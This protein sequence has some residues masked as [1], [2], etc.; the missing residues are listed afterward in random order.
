MVVRRGGC[1]VE[2]RA[3]DHHALARVGV[4]RMVVG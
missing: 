3:F 4:M 1:V 2:R